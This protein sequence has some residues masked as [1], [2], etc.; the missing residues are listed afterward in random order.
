MKSFKT[1][2]KKT[3]GISKLTIQEFLTLTIEIKAV[4]N[5]RPITLMSSD[6]T[7]LNPVT[8]RHILIGRSLITP[9]E[10]DIRNNPNNRLSR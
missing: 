9:L 4:L 1:H 6:S 5:S 7:D 2:L 8:P 10:P 3:I